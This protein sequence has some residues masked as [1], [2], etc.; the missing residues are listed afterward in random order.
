MKELILRIL[1][2]NF[3]IELGH[4]KIRLFLFCHGLPDRSPN[5]L[6][7]KSPIC[8]RCIGLIAGF[9][10]I[11]FYHIQRSNVFQ[12]LWGI[13]LIVPVLIDGFTQNLGL[14]KSNNLLRFVTGSTGGLGLSLCLNALL[15]LKN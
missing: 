12:L 11:L 8:Y 7:H 14:R 5:F 4:K 9:I 15:P 1:R 6:G 2:T 13:I 10:P 3:T